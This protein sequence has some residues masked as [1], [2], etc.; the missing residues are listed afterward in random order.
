MNY[1][2]GS[3]W[4]CS[5]EEFPEGRKKLGDNVIRSQSFHTLWYKSV[6]A[7]TDPK[8]IL[9]I[10]SNSPL[11]P[12]LNLED[13]RIEF[14]SLDENYGAAANCETKFSGWLRSCLLGV[15]YAWLCEA[16]YFVYI[17]QDVLISGEG[18][19]EYAISNMKHAFMF[20]SGE[21]TP[22][23]IQQSLFIV[24]RDGF[25]EFMERMRQIR[26]SDKE[27]PPEAKF[28]RIKYDWVPIRRIGKM[29]RKTTSRL[30]YDFLPFGY[31]RTRPIGWG[32]HFIY[33]Q[34]GSRQEVAKYMKQT[35]L[36]LDLD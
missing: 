8:K 30:W 18:I 17:E 35:G 3:G 23:P 32:D 1:V 9:I 13:S 16:D 24:H 12:P 4:W 2:I 28:T 21:G 36:Y 26:F 29:W 14:V 20:G 25:L 7:F 27:M 31:G 11:K 22:Q 19:I 33:F 5:D 10:D 34:H 6:C 15:C